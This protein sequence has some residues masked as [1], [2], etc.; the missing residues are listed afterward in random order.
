MLH[1]RMYHT[2]PTFSA[3]TAVIRALCILV[4]AVN[5]MLLTSCSSTNKIS[6]DYKS[7]TDFHRYKTFS[8][9]N[10]SSEISEGDQRTIQHIVE[11][12]LI[13]NGFVMTQ[14]NA[15]ILLDMNIIK[16][17]TTGEG[18][19]LGLSIGLPIGSHGAIGLGTDKLLKGDNQI[20]GL[21]IVDITAQQTHQ[22]IWRGSAEGVPMS[23]FFLRNEL[24]LA[25]VIHDL[26]SQFP[27]K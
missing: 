14:S 13:K 15:D 10:F 6:Q 17:R 8:W 12:N 11:N 1:K 2:T 26:I 25:S 18:S 7:D 23:Y 21:I 27:P 4:I 9:H 22:I 3:Q 16:Q 5:T 19:R 20:A 24:Q